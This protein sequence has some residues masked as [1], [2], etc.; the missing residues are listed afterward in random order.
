MQTVNL[1]FPLVKSLPVPTGN[2]PFQGRFTAAATG[3]KDEGYAFIQAGD[4][5]RSLELVGV[6]ND[7]ETS[8]QGSQRGDLRMATRAVLSNAF[9]RPRG[10]EAY[11]GATPQVHGLQYGHGDHMVGYFP[12]VTNRPPIVCLRWEERIAGT[13]PHAAKSPFCRVARTVKTLTASKEPIA[14][15]RM[16]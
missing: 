4:V 14:C 13:A 11:N 10:G 12:P 16:V 2:A 5:V 15:P 3:S 9:Y 1:M 7:V 8:L 6:T